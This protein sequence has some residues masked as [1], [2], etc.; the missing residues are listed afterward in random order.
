MVDPATYNDADPI[1]FLRVPGTRVPEGQ[2]I[3]WAISLNMCPA[4][5]DF[6][7]TSAGSISSIQVMSNPS[8]QLYSFV[9][10]TNAP[11]GSMIFRASDNALCR[12]LMSFSINI[13]SPSL[14]T[15]YGSSLQLQVDNNR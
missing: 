12:L 5:A 15:L 6:L 14:S 4:V 3:V 2:G 10:G 11:S 7:S 8:S 1:E 13:T 9:P